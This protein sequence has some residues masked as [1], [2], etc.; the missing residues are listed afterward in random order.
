MPSLRAAKVSTVGTS[1]AL[2]VSPRL[3]VVLTSPCTSIPLVACSL[4]QTTKQAAT[5]SALILNFSS[6]ILKHSRFLLF[7]L[8]LQHL[9]DSCLLGSQ[10]QRIFSRRLLSPVPFVSIY[11]YH[12]LARDLPLS[13]PPLRLSH[14]RIRRAIARTLRVHHLSLLAC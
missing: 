1:M 6:S 11:Q 3:T 4:H 12:L 5:A 13:P 7:F 8:S 2:K 14:P 9:L 10:L